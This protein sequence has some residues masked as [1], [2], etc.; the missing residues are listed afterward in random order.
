M[1]LAPQETSVQPVDTVTVT[2]DGIDVRVP[3][4]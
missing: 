1:T 3:K 4:G 2:V